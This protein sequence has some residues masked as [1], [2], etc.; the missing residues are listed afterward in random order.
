MRH[1]PGGNPRGCLE[2]ASEEALSV[3]DT[4]V[5]LRQDVNTADTLPRPTRRPMPL[6][7]FWGIAPSET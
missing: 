5:R 4:L 1:G 3:R 7:R 6:M 2:L